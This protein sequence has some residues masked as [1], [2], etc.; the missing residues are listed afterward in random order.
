MKY[1]ELFGRFNESSTED[2]IEEIE[3][4]FIEL[5]DKNINVEVNSS[6]LYNNKN[7]SI[8]QKIDNVKR[9]FII[10]VVYEYHKDIFVDGI[11]NK[12]IE[13]LGRDYDIVGNYKHRA[14]ALLHDF[15][16]E[17]NVLKWEINIS[18]KGLNESVNEDSNLMIV[19]VQKSFSK[20]F[21]P[22]Y[23]TQLKEYAKSY[24]NVYQIWDNHIDGHNVDKDYLYDKK[25]DT[26]SMHNDLYAFENQ[27]MLI[28]KRY[29]YDV[30]AKF[31]KKILDEK[32]FKIVKEKEKKGLLKRGEIFKTN[33]GTI[34]VY[35][36]NKHVWFHCPKKLYELLLKLKGKHLTMVGGSD[37]ECLSDVFTTC[38]SI[39]VLVKRDWGYIYS[40]TN[41]PIK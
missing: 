23:I 33:E 5:I 35:I 6:R 25:P 14:C 24:S 9:G 31:F 37:S 7:L 1:L 27:K 2:S 12:A 32:T 16:E 36:G 4:H 39:G 8:A 26:P 21:T 28:E 13:R 34:I 41:C 29:S 40:A 10:T 20:F 22:N 17:E 11:I 38:E 15:D 18:P 19:D 3:D 30:D